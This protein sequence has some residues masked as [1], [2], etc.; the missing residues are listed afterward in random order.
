MLELKDLPS[1]DT[2]SQF[3]KLY[4]NPDVDG[5]RTW[6]LLSRSCSD[7]MGDFEQNLARHG[8]SQTK[9]FVL[10]LL[11]RNPDGLGVRRLAEGVNVSSPTMTGIIDRLEHAKLCRRE[12]DASDRRA[13]V[14]RL[15]PAGETLLAAALP[16]HYAW[17]AQ[18][19]SV[20]SQDER[21]QLSMLMRK[22][23]GSVA[24]IRAAA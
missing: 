23:N 5:V 9:F 8:L 15:L 6:L 1:F 2:L 16:E 3:A 11:K 7:M 21:E 13:W 24:Q 14:V 4:P 17:V 19:M 10:L 18:L 12:Q 20:F 22:L